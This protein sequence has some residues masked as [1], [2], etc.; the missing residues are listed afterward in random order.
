MVDKENQPPA[1]PSTVTKK[2]PTGPTR[3]DSGW[4]SAR[5]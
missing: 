1:T 5:K 3:Q 4:L 2:Q